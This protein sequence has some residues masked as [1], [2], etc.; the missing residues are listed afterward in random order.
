MTPGQAVDELRRLTEQLDRQAPTDVPRGLT[1]VVRAYTDVIV[2]DVRKAMLVLFGAVGLVLLLASA[3]G[4][5]LLLLRSEAKRLDFSVRA[6]LGASRGRLTRQ[7]LAE[8][9]LVALCAGAIGLAATWWTLQG[10][11]ALVPEGLPRAESVRVDAGVIA[12]AIAAVLLTAVL[13]GMAP[14]WSVARTDS[15]LQLRTAAGGAVNAAAPRIRRVLV[16]TQVALAVMVI[17]VAALLIRT[18]VQ[19]QRVDMGLAT[20]RLVFVSLLLP[21]ARYAE[22][23]TALRF[24]KALVA[25]LE[26]APDIAAATPVNV[27]PFGGTGGWDAPQVTAEGQ[28]A[29]QGAANPSVNLESLHPNYFQTLQVALARGRAFDEADSDLAPNVAIVSEDVAARV[30]PGQNPIGKRIK[31]GPPASKD[32]WRTIVGVAKPTRYRELTRPR[33]TLYLPAA[34]FNFTAEMLVL[35]TGAPMASVLPLVRER[36]HAVDPSV[37]VMQLAPFSEMLDRPL[38][39]PRFNAFVIA[40]FG[41]AALALAGIGL[42]AMLAASVRLRDTEIGVRVALGATASDVRRLMVGEGLRLAGA[43][44][45]IGLVCAVATTRI[46][47]GLLSDVLPLDPPALMS[48]ALVVMGVSAVACYLPAQRATRIDPVRLLRSN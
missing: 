10:L 3:N 24:L 14:V 7:V 19:L 8:S 28:D 31:L 12:F 15:I 29:A 39:R 2:G 34:Q 13:A 32:A 9:V 22:R 18:L 23:P 27:R 17:A 30:W 33:P 40:V 25:Q 4:A 45:V 43:G 35:R 36:V 6:A 42:Y 20:D 44:A 1:P 46:L 16:V 48:A 37:Q 47:Q 21:Q 26:A 41:V 5:N 11:V 38:A